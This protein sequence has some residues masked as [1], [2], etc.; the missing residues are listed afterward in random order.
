LTAISEPRE[1]NSMNSGLFR[2]AAGAG[3]ATGPTIETK[4]AA[5]AALHKVLPVSAQATAE[6]K[7]FCD[8]CVLNGMNVRNKTTYDAATL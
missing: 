3:I 5:S 2:V 6:A 7:L 1:N 8:G 4:A